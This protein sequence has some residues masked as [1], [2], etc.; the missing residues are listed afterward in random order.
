MR[1]EDDPTKWLEIYRIDDP[2]SAG[3]AGLSTC[4]WRRYDCQSPTAYRLRVVGEDRSFLMCR[5]HM[6]ELATILGLD[7]PPES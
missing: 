3:V 4:Q 1:G 5:E 2:L 7:P 6:R